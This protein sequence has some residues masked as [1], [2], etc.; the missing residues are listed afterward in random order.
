[1]KNISRTEQ[2]KNRIIESLINLMENIPFNKITMSQIASEAEVNRATIYRIFDDKYDIIEAKENQFLEALK[3][4]R[5]KIDLFSFKQRLNGS[6]N[7]LYNI[8]KV[9]DE[10]KRFL[11]IVIG[12]NGEQSFLPRFQNFLI[13]ESKEH[14]EIIKK[15]LPNVNP[16][17]VEIYHI[18][19]AFGVIVYWIKQDSLTIQEVYNFIQQYPFTNLQKK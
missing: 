2:T 12:P 16:K 19:A 17:L 7:N 14:H 13:K 5:G 18:N 11:N 1:M 10:N 8:L 9:I 4:A 6:S 15:I 3:S